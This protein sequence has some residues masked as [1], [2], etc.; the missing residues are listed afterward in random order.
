MSRAV[1]MERIAEA[2]PQRR[3][4]I[5][6]LIY[7][8]HFLTGAVAY[9]SFWLVV[10]GDAAATATN[11]QAH[12]PLFRLGFAA[13]LINLALYIAVTALF[14]DLFRPVNRSLSLLAAFFSLVG[15]AIQ[16]LSRLSYLAPLAVLG[17]A[18][19][20]SVFK[21]EQLHALALLFSVLFDQAYNI[22]M[23]FFGFYC[24]LIGYLI[25][26][27][28]FLPRILGVLM[29]FAGL[30]WLT[31]LYPPLVGYLSP[32]N[33][34]VGALAELSLTLWL[35][36]MGVKVERWKEQAGAA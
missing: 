35:L 12:E 5:A 15:C 28:T 20:L 27:S 33:L 6:G 10:P 31:F 8:L 25:F 22:G 34:Y 32:Y 24:L 2:S 7:L 26:R 14:Y 11:I 21:A 36:V 23:V 29:S 16:A 4:R 30:A 13:F 18:P 19:Y 17:G 9:S 3:A 1:K